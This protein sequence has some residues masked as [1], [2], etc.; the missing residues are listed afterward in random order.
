[1]TPFSE[2]ASSSVFA[3]RTVTET[4]TTVDA[5]AV[6]IAISADIG[7]RIAE[8]QAEIDPGQRSFPGLCTNFPRGKFVLALWAVDRALVLDVVDSHDQR[9]TASPAV[10][11]EQVSIRHVSRQARLLPK[12]TGRSPEPWTSVRR[13]YSCSRCLGPVTSQRLLIAPRPDYRKEIG[14]LVSRLRNCRRHR[15]ISGR[16]SV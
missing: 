1:M 12:V 4:T 6:S 13:S 8:P 9:F 2:R 5:H 3:F 14:R 15:N 10:Y 7:Q 16:G 11:L